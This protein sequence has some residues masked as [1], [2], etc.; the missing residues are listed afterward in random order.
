MKIKKFTLIELIIVIGIIGIL[1]AM[2]FPLLGK[3]K[4][5]AKDISCKSLL[6]QYGLAIGM[7][8]NDND[9]WMVDC[10][11][12]LNEGSDFLSYF[13]NKVAYENVAR[14][15]G[16]QPTEAL[17]RLKHFEIDENKF[18][19]VSIAPSR[20]NVS[21]SAAPTSTGITQMY[22]KSEESGL[23]PSKRGVFFD[24]QFDD[25]TATTEINY[26]M[27]ILLQKQPVIWNFHFSLDI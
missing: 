16:D 7:Y 20:A 19:K 18:I 10:R 4:A 12:Y 14:C 15:P 27:T 11:N 21:D 24:Y 9:D 5:K 3:A 13:G 26:H 17:G 22:I 25:M 8:C 23:N 1:C 6:K 2:L